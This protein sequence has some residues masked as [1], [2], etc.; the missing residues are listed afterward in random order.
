MVISYIYL[1][2]WHMKTTFYVRQHSV[3]YGVNDRCYELPDM[4]SG[5]DKFWV[6]L[7]RLYYP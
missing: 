1:T 7:Q 5:L 2:C 6:V 3:S 4:E